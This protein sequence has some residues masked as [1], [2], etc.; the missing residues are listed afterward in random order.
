MALFFLVSY[1]KLPNNKYIL[2]EMILLP[3]LVSLGI[4]YYFDLQLGFVTYLIALWIINF[5]GKMSGV[6]AATSIISNLVENKSLVDL[7]KNTIIYI[8]YPLFCFSISFWIF[9]TIKEKLNLPFELYRW[10]LVTGI[11]FTYTS[12]KYFYKEN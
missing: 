4:Y 5:L 9:L 3:F 1:S 6:L 2:I 7:I 8:W 11:F 10:I 12:L